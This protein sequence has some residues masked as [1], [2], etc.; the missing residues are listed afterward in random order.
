M[1]AYFVRM[2]NAPE[3]CMPTTGSTVPA[4]PEWLHVI[5]YDGFRLRGDA[6]AIASG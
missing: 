5:N 1:N 3:V 4:G 2:L 6:M